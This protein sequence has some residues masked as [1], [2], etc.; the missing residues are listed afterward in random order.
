MTTEGEPGSIVY[1]ALEEE[2]RWRRAGLT[3]SLGR[4]ALEE[5]WAKQK[6]VGLGNVSPF[7]PDNSPH[8]EAWL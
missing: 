3:L 6:L 4:V 1:H 7:G 5:V 8:L 2:S